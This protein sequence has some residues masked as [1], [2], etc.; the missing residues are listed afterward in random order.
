MGT[1][2]DASREDGGDSASGSA[3]LEATEWRNLIVSSTSRNSRPLLKGVSQTQ[4][5]SVDRTK[6]YTQP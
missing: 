4:M 3:R 6:T 1:P 5:I 2:R